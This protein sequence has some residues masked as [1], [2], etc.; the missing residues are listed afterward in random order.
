MHVINF[1]ML[2]LCTIGV[3]NTK[4]GYLNSFNW[5]PWHSWWWDTLY[6]QAMYRTPCMYRLCTGHPVCTG[7][8]QDTLY[9]KGVPQT[10][11]VS[12]RLES[13]LR[14]LN[15]FVTFS[16]K[17]SITCMILETITTQFSLSYHFQN[18]VCLFFVLLTLPEIRRI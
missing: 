9:V 17:P 6:V 16:R 7:C 15:L 1:L 2:F 3:F 5:H 4:L 14:A 18:V 8:V 12:R 10:M 11:T 13:C